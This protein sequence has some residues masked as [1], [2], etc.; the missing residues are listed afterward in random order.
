MFYP[1]LCCRIHRKLFKLH[2]VNTAELNID[3]HAC[4]FNS[5]FN[6]NP[7]YFPLFLKMNYL[8]RQYNLN[9]ISLPVFSKYI[10]AILSR[11]MTPS[12]S[13]IRKETL[14]RYNNKIEQNKI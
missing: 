3:I 4:S 6:R 12:L 13:F 14:Q 8:H 10:S 9:T 5:A 7:A 1:V 2:I 11:S